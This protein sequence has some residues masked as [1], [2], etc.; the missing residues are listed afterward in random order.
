VS[1]QT[2]DRLVTPP[3]RALARL[4]GKPGLFFDQ[5]ADQF[6]RDLRIEQALAAFDRDVDALT[7]ASVCID[8]GAN[9]G[10]YTQRLAESGASVHAF[11]PDPAAFAL[12]QQRVGHMPN[13]HLHNAAIGV[14][15][16]TVVLYRERES[17]TAPLLS[18]G[19]SIMANAPGRDRTS[20]EVP[21]ID[22]MRF[23]RELGRPVDLVKMDIE[24]AEIE[25]LEGLL[26]APERE[27]VA[28]MYVETHAWMHPEQLVPLARLRRAFRK[29]ERPRINFDW[30]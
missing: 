2:L 10:V 3:V 30:P 7:A 6:G 23:L 19:S 21:C 9:L 4:P 15:D 11:E 16:G 5:V 17:D 28:A 20:V 27:R 22:F 25:I 29:L 24:G 1:R 14:R 8:L 13:V 12:L 18:T 26:H